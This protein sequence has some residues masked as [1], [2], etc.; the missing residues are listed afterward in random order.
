MWKLIEF[1][2]YPTYVDDNINRFIECNNIE[3]FEVA[4]YK[5]LWNDEVNDFYTFVLIKYWYED[6]QN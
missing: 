4:G 6:K 1:M 3:E 2:G 5:V